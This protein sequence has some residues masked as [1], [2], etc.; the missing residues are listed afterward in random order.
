M[1]IDGRRWRRTDPGID[2]RTRR[3][4]VDELMSARRAVKAAKSA[5]DDDEIAVA[6]GRV[7]DAK[8]ALG[9]RGPSWWEP[10]SPADLHVR[11]TAAMSAL[12][13]A[14]DLEGLLDGLHLDLLASRSS[15]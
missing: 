12:A 14:E 7:N 2:E 4:L 3:A 10:V 11:R 13:E 9:E 8:I 1:V 5:A 6:R 15:G